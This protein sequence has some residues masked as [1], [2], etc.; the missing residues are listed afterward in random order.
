MNDSNLNI[1][2][3]SLAYH[4]LIGGAELATQEITNRI[5]ERFVCFTYRFDDRWPRGEKIGN[6]EI[7]RVG[8][9]KSTSQ[10]YGRKLEKIG[11]IWKAWRAAEASH[12]ER[13]LDAIWS[14]MAGFSGFSALLFKLRHPKI[15]FILTL[16][17]GDSEEH[18]KKRLGIFY[19]I[20]K[21]VL[22]KA[23][24]IQTISSFLADLAKRHGANCPIEVIPN[25]V[26]ILQIDE[27][28]SIAKKEKKKKTKKII[29]TTSR[30]VRKNGVDIL[31]KAAAKL[32]AEKAPD[33]EVW[34]LGSGPLEQELKILAG[35]LDV[36]EEVKF[37]GEI[38]NK[39][40]F[41]YLA[42]ADIF[43]R[44]SRS[45]GLGNSFLEAMAAKVPVIGTKVGGIPDI[46]THKE[47]GLL[48][49][50][51]ND[52]DIKNQIKE[53][54]INQKLV[55]TL[56]KNGRAQAEKFD[57]ENIASKMKLIFEKISEPHLLIATGIYPPEIGGAATYSKRL[58]SKSEEFKCKVTV[59]TYGEGQNGDGIFYISRKHKKGIRHI[60]YFFKAFRLA[61]K[62]SLVYAVDT[63]FGAAT[64]SSLAAR[65]ARK[66]YIIRVTGDYAWEQGSQRFGVTD[67]IETFQN[68]KY[69]FPVEILR[70]SQSYTVKKAAKVI[71]PSVFLA[72]LASG[73]GVNPDKIKVVLNSVKKIE[74][75]NKKEAR[76]KLGL[77]GKVIFSSGRLVPWKGFECLIETVKELRKEIPKLRLVI[78]GDGPDKEAL[79]AKIPASEINNIKILGKIS[80][81]VVVEYLSAADIFILNTGYEGLS[82]QL[83]E[84]LEVK[85]LPIATTYRTG[86][87]ELID[88]KD[89]KIE[90][91]EY[92][93]QAS[94]EE[95]I[96]KIIKSKPS[97]YNRKK[98]SDLTDD[99]SEEVMLKKVSEI[100]YS[101]RK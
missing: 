22:K 5:P 4:P 42:K 17:E 99:F 70:R 16:Q 62:N 77:E 75:I 37:F 63:S 57:W 36:S 67:D 87:K 94:I 12:E 44:P 98:I 47:T 6:I 48:A 71:T 15:P 35:R 33:F 73:W 97:T 84:A 91:I 23:D 14:I 11:Y 82:H 50:P 88:I 13:P 79:Q 2:I 43:V 61:R 3:F 54:L 60:I 93:N 64:I 18:I 96:K 1:G 49:E 25:G 9:G 92:N 8:R 31:I 69:K 78:A 95:I 100:I 28:V 32:K 34:I 24:S 53:L 68:K 41:M 52:E 90:T 58:I 19:P 86:N 29:I 65:L 46:I 89:F 83:I 30:L 66:K 39:D 7:V 51:E 56:Q 45:E 74:P 85:N 59:L 81:D 38:K 72:D 27:S 76:K 20:W 55:K 101:E 21:L 26:D 80:K 40:V 10:H